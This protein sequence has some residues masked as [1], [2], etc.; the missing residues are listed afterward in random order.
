MKL[1]RLKLENFQG[2]RAM[3]LDPQGESQSVFGRNATGKTTLAS[4]WSWILF[5]K[6]S[7]GS[8]DFQI[9]TLSPEGEAYSG[10][11]HAVEA[12]VQIEGR[13]KTLRRV[14][15]ETWTKR[16]G[17]AERQLTGHTTDYYVDGVPLQ[18]KEYDAEISA[19]APE[20]I[21][22]LLTDP[23]EFAERLHWKRR[24]EL[25]L[26]ICG[27]VERSEVI[28][29]HRPL[30]ALEEILGDRKLSDHKRVIA[31]RRTE[32]NRE[33]AVIPARI[34]EATRALPELPEGEGAEEALRAQ[35]EALKSKLSEAV[36]EHQ[37]VL[38]GGEVAE[39]QRRISEIETAMNGIELHLAR[40][41]EAQSAAARKAISALKDA[42][43]DAERRARTARSALR[44]AKE[45]IGTL[46]TRAEAERER[47]RRLNDS[48]LEVKTGDEVCAACGRPLPA[49]DVEEARRRA[50]DEL[51]ADRA[52]RLEEIREGG[53]R[54]NAKRE[55]LSASL[56]ALETEMAA[57][58]IE[59]EELE[60][61]VAAAEI[62]MEAAAPAAA[63]PAEDPEYQSLGYERQALAAAVEEIKRDRVSAAAEAQVRVDALTGE[64]GELDERIA[65]FAQHARG[66]ERVAELSAQER[67]LAAELEELERQTFLA[68]EYERQEAR[69]MDER[70]N[71]RF[72]L[73][74]FQL[75]RN[76]VNGGLEECCEVTYGGVP[77]SSGLNHGSRIAIGLDI[78]STLQDHY[79]FRPPVFVDQAESFT[80]L[81]EMDCQV[82]RLVVS[83]ADEKLRI[84][85]EEAES[86]E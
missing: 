64:A 59:A 48:P 71:A 4:A 5:G 68:E 20:E 57:A 85:A 35:R 8:A 56:P 70:I 3:T 7:S 44:D 38:S 82:I 27:K 60:S 36:A 9:K 81:P 23:L 49:E 17:E 29:A 83:A 76:L 79:G 21:F 40:E 77:Y 41:N 50:M 47:F 37:R 18:K 75:F 16:R 80:S 72:R 51:N 32:I 63:T 6:D 1:L 13:S 74:R 53:L 2:I 65:L 14:Y 46:E 34:D 62:E 84:E 73:A 28:A 33:L 58:E 43:Q 12:L 39:K 78:I 31:A 69:L 42:L 86:D 15:R 66:T 10:L 61:K 30:A 54:I 11:D 52:R 19:I 24:R 45:E 67:L 26:E 25:L 22:R 55:A